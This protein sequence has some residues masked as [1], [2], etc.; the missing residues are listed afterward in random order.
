M[1]TD[2][3]TERYINADRLK[4]AFITAGLFDIG[5]LGVILPIIDQQPH[6]SLSH[7]AQTRGCELCQ[8][9]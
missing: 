6:I 9:G 8:I 2:V 7:K 4:E 1:Q 3:K 5:E